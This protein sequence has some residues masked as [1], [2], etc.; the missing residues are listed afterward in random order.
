MG[1][2]TVRQRTAL[3]PRREPYWALIKTGRHIGYRKT[4]T[5]GSWIARAY[6]GGTRKRLYQALDA[7]NAAT[8]SD[9][10]TAAAAAAAEWFQHLD[11][12][13][14]NADPTV[15]E[16][17]ALYVEHQAE[18]KSATAAKDATERFA[19]YVNDEP[20]ARIP[21][22]KLTPA[23]VKT[24]RSNLA[25]SPAIQ[26]KRGK[27]YDDAPTRPDRTRSASSINRDM[28]ALRAALRLALADGMV[29]TD[30][31]WRQALKPIKNA[32]RRRDLYLDKAQRR[33]LLKAMP[34]DLAAFARALCLIPLR[35]GALAKL[36]VADF[37]KRNGALLIRDD[38]AGA[39]RS[40]ALPSQT[41][42][43]LRT[44]AKDKLPAAFLFTRA[45]GQPWEK[46]GWK[47]LVKRGVEEAGIPAEA[48]LYT[49]RHCTITDLVSAG[50]DLFTVAKL[51]GTSVLMIERHYGHLQAAQT[52]D[53]LQGLAL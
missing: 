44:Q 1:I 2:E 40:I 43:L 5:G 21:I 52:R 34:D 28:V 17:C 32:D 45:D 10:Y 30:F 6:D 35:P 51:A 39:G 25:K 16:I 49:L 22:R 33:D 9:Q 36:R 12:G 38:K 46:D 11:A 15:R 50:T 41:A 29:T 53:A 19:R 20:I 42:D 47:K 27:K 37:D 14:T 31:A 3:E 8:P 7:A 23:H 48:T 13:G 26:P 24:W 4:E 18:H